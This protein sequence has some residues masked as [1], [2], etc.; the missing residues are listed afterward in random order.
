MYRQNLLMVKTL[1]ILCFAVCP[2]EDIF[3]SCPE[4]RKSEEISTNWEAF[5]F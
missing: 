2:L 1:V 5:P 3:T 4:D